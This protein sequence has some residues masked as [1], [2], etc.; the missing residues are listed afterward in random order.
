MDDSGDD[1]AS[2]TFAIVNDVLAY[3]QAAKIEIDACSYSPSLWL[4]H[5]DRQ[6]LSDGIDE[7]VRALDTSGIDG[8]VVPDVVEVALR[9]GGD[10]QPLHRA[11]DLARSAV[12]RLCPRDF[13]RS[14]SLWIVVVS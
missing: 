14:A 7:L 5:Q 6:A 11:L 2:S 8:N 3:R 4:Q 9:G 12:R 10:A 13:T 1:D